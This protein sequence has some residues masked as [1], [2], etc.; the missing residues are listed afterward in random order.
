MADSTASMIFG[1]TKKP[2]EAWDFLKWYLSTDTQTNYANTLQSTYG[3]EYR[4]NTANLNA[5]K[6]L[7]YSEEDLQVILGQWKWQKENLQHPAG[8]MS[9]RELSNAWINVVV[10]GDGIAE[11]L[12]KAVLQSDREIL[13]K[14]QEFGYCDEDG[15]IIKDYKLLTAKDLYEMLEKKEAAKQ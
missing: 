7:Q 10:N 8:Y 14:M 1:N 9:E 12:D 15:N 5:F 13:R 6:Q 11:A 4:L 3:S 2:N